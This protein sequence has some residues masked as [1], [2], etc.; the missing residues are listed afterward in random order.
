MAN[1]LLKAEDGFRAKVFL[2][3]QQEHEVVEIHASPSPNFPVEGYLIQIIKDDN[4]QPILNDIKI[5]QT[6]RKEGIVHWEPL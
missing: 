1:V 5:P 4:N 6:I 2:D 3:E